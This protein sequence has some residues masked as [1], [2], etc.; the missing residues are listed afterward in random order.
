MAVSRFFAASVLAFA[1]AAPASAANFIVSATV[2][3]GTLTPFQLNVVDID[4]IA[5]DVGDT[6]DLTIT[7]SGGTL[8]L[9]GGGALWTGLLT[10][11]DVGGVTTTSTMSFTGG[12]ANLVANAGPMTQVNEFVHVG[13]Y[14]GNSLIQSAPGPISFS[15]INQMMT[16]DSADFNGPRTY[17]RA[18]FYYETSVTPSVVP[19]PASWAMLIAGFGLVGALARRRRAIAA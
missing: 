19:E 16:F 14:F 6:L 11:D 7:F 10:G 18:F 12:S 1:I 3:S 2:N 17:G 9:G 13:N 4:P 15:G 8:T 5:I